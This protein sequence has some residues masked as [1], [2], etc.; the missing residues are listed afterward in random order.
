[1]VRVSPRRPAGSTLGRAWGAAEATSQAGESDVTR[2]P[3]TSNNP[4]GTAP[5]NVLDASGFSRG[6]ERGWEVAGSPGLGRAWGRAA[7]PPASP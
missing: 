3:V 6:R 1:M 4:D 5:E 7:A 2:D